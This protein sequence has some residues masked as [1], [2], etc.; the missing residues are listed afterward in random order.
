MKK[1][2]SLSIYLMLTTAL[3]AESITALVSG[4]SMAGSVNTEELKYYKIVAKQGQ[5]LNIS[6]T[7]VVGDPDLYL[8]IGTKPTNIDFDKESDNSANMKEESILTLAEDADVFIAVYGYDTGTYT[9]NAT[10][11]TSTTQSIISDEEVNSSVNFEEMKYYKIAGKEGDTIDVLLT[12]IVGDADL[13]IKSGSKPTKEDFDAES[14]NGPNLDELLSKTLIQDSTLYIGVYG[15]QAATYKLKATVSSVEEKITKR[16]YEDAEDG[17]TLR[18]QIIDNAPSGAK[19]SN[20]YDNEKMSKVINFSNPNAAD[21]DENAY[22]LGG[23]WNNRENFNIKWDMKTTQEYII[24]V[25]LITQNG[26][27][28]LRYS[29]YHEDYISADEEIT[30]GL[31]KTSINGDWHTFHRNLVKDLQ[32]VEPD[33]NI[34]SVESFTVR[35]KGSFDNIELYSDP[36]KVYEDAEDQT[37]NKWSVY[38]GADANTTS[39]VYDNERQSNVISLNGVDY[40]SQYLIGGFFNSA[41][42][43]KDN[44]HK[45]IKWSIKHSDDAIIQVNVNTTHGERY[46]EYTNDDI[47]ISSIDGDEIIYGI[48]SNSS[49]GKWHTFIRDL[50]NDIQTFEPNNQ[51]LSVEGMVILG[52]TKIDDIELFNVS[53]PAN[54]KA[55]LS[56][57]F[58][59]TDVTG[60]FSLRDILLKYHV[61]PTFFVSYFSE[62]NT[63]EI[64]KLKTLEAD[65]DE[66]GCHTFTHGGIERDYGNDPARIDEYINEQ[67]IPA[68]DAMVAA[69]FNPKSFAHP[70]GETEK[71]FDTAIRSYF[72][73][74]RGL[75]DARGRLVQRDDIFFKKGNPYNMLVA[76][77]IDNGYRDLEQIREA[78]IRARQRGEIISLYGHYI[79]N[80]YNTAYIV[81]YDELKKILE[82]ANEIGLQS[83][84][85]KETFR[86]G[87]N[88]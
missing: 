42:A 80:D 68:R 51:L 34:I 75:S 87:E 27:K 38:L 23:Q 45:N 67:I 9:I 20:I 18:W 19:V 61:T 82:M 55:G 40:S 17:S 33:N 26:N 41:N 57:T 4:D 50:S 31:G 54:H 11:T 73:Y 22:R 43:W 65:G 14:D 39:N 88:I 70:Y 85:Y 58:D 83:Y 2:I 36:Y 7:D 81:P 64:N 35:A 12:E 15:Y 86:L 66:I 25:E 24:D 32:L 29:D 13:Y 84:T 10:L 62:F 78:M 48:G 77:T 28:V 49:N 74:L 46:L 69:G 52:N 3:Y 6:L 44:T 21:S 59:D 53:Y 60:W 8:K 79:K 47:S 5:I 72:P 37:T 30:L 63:D 16:M 71:S 76:T 56:L 1:I